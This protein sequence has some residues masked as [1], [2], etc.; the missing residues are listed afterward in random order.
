MIDTSPQQWDI[1]TEAAKQLQLE[2]AQQVVLSDQLSSDIR[3]VAGTDV[4]FENNL[5][6][7][8][9][10]VVILSYPELELVEYSIA[11][12]PTGFPYIPGYL[13]FR[14]CPALLDALEKINRT[15]D[16]I[17]CDGQGIAHPRRFGIACHLGVLTNIP[18]IG[19]AKSRLTGRYTDPGPN[20]GDW[21]TLNHKDERLGSVLRTRDNTRPLFIS[22]GHK[23]SVQTAQEWVLRCTTRYRLPET[24]RWADGIASNRPAFIKRLKR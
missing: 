22:P 6:I 17:L 9:A 13:S 12:R 24:T 18:T 2:L 5:S 11:K 15:P 20:R 10:A 19:V 1:T 14:E 8:R 21:Q 4:G 23:V 7:T 16:L 3:W